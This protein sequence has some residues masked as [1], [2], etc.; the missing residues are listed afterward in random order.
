[1]F[2]R[3]KSFVSRN[4]A[5]MSAGIMSA[6][7]MLSTVAGAAEGDFDLAATMTSS[8]QSIVTNLLSMIT[9]V[10]PITIT[11]LA[12]SIG[13]SYGIRFIKKIVGKAG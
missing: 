3:I 8:V 5:A 10:L 11:L 2:K 1:M 9:A 7:F 12:A 6:M 4:R 13:I